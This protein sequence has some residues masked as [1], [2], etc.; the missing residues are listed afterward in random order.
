MKK[1]NIAQV[2][3]RDVY[4]NKIDRN[5]DGHLPTWAFDFISVHPV[6]DF[7]KKINKRFLGFS[8]CSP[9]ILVEEKTG[10]RPDFENDVYATKKNAILAAKKIAKMYSIH[11]VVCD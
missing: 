6:P 7:G 3:N 11:V 2:F 1:P 5:D 4:W 10:T 8:F 9:M